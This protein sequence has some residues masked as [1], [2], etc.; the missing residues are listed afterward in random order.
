MN[1]VMAESSDHPL[2]EHG[3][4]M[5]PKHHDYSKHLQ[6]F[7][8]SQHHDLCLIHDPCPCLRSSTGNVADKHQRMRFLVRRM[9][10]QLPGLRFT[11]DKSVIIKMTLCSIYVNPTTNNKDITSRDETAYIN[12]V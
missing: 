1:S 8:L 2:F 10:I 4:G 12:C 7:S 3:S 9:E 11:F 6:A 5:L